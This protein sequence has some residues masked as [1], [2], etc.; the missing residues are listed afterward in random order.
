MIRYYAI[1]DHAEYGESQIVSKT[2][3]HYTSG[4]A[5]SI[6]RNRQARED[7]A[8]ALRCASQEGFYNL[9]VVRE[10]IAVRNGVWVETD[11]TTTS[12]SIPDLTFYTS[13]L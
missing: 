8:D 13:Q 9:R 3:R 4:S 6:R 12:V 11:V 7:L 10:T 2:Y 1:A 5:S